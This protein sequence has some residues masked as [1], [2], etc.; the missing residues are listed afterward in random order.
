MSHNATGY[1]WKKQNILTLRHAASNNKKL[2]GLPLGKAISRLVVDE[3]G[4]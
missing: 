4:L 3:I 2:I 1:N